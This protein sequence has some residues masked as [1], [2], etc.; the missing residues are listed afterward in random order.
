[1]KQDAS[2]SEL[3]TNSEYATDALTEAEERS[4]RVGDALCVR[5]DLDR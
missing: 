4:L 1:M 5:A 2:H 3:S